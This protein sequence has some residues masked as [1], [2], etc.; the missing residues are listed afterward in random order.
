MYRI[1]EISVYGKS[2]FHIATIESVN[3]DSRSHPETT[4]S[5]TSIRMIKY[6]CKCKTSLIHARVLGIFISSAEYLAFLES[7]GEGEPLRWRVQSDG[8]V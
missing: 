4:K 7:D 2:P 1:W 5:Y 8:A 6:A 3:V